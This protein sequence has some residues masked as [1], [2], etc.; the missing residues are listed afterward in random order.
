MKL[1]L[2]TI[3]VWDGVKSNSEC[4]LCDL[5]LNAETDAIAYYL[6]SSVMHPETRVKVNERGFCPTH[7]QAL[8]EAGSPQSLALIGHTYIQRTREELHTPIKNLANT[9]TGKKTSIAVRRLVETVRKREHGCMVCTDMAK[10]LERYAYT[11]VHLWRDDQDFR[12]EFSQG[13]GV[14]L[15]HMESLLDVAPKVLKT[16][17]FQQ[18]S[19]ELVQMVQDNLKRLEDDIWWMTQKYKAEHIDSPWNG[20][21]DA[22]RRL[23]GKIIGKGRVFSDS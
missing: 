10:R 2:E 14:C 19:S 1:Q 3:P 16:E 21:E 22:H 6:G 12:Q 17:T 13:K 7:W 9:R 15:H 20:C 8:A 5:M 18:F 4:F 11:T 23:V